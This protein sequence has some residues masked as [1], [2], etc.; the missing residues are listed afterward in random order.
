[1]KLRLRALKVNIGAGC[2]RFARLYYFVRTGYRSGKIQTS[3]PGMKT[4]SGSLCCV[5]P[6]L[7]AGVGMNP[8][9]DCKYMTVDRC[10]FYGTLKLGQLSKKIVWGCE[11][12]R[13][14]WKTQ[15]H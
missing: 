4:C 15:I 13:P 8:C 10:W 11:K 5:L 6:E 7:V 3:G 2:R 12:Y 9:K 14:W 1:M